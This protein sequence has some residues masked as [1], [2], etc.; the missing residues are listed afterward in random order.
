MM[1]VQFSEHSFDYL[2]PAEDG[3]VRADLHPS[4][5]IFKA[6]PNGTLVQ[7]LGHVSSVNSNRALRV[8][9]TTVFYCVGR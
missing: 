5:C 7:Y 9:L 8:L 2:H 4:A 3:Y 1:L 6:T